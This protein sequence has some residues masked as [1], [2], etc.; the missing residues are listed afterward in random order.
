MADILK[1]IQKELP[2]VISSANFEGANIVLY[3]NDIE[4]FKDN[5]GKIKELVN[6]FKKRIE[7]RADEKLLKSEEDTEKII[8]E[9]VPKEAELTAILFDSQRSIVVIEAKRPGLVIGKSGLILKEIKDNS[10]WIP[11]IQRSPAIESKI[12][13]NI[14]DV[15]YQNNNT[16]KKFLNSVGKKIYKEWNPE[17]VEEWIR[18]TFLGGGRQVGRSCFLLSTPQT[19]ILL[20]CGINVAGK[21]K[22]KFPY[23]DVS[24]FK[25]NELDAI[26]LSHAHLDHSGLIP[27]LFKMGYRGP[28][29][30]TAPTRDVSALL[31]LDFIGV[32]YKQAAAP[33][34]SSTDI[35][36]MVKHTICLEYNEVTDIAPDMRITLYNSGH[37]LGSSIVH[38]NI[39]NGA[40][41]LIYT[42]D[43]KFLKSQLLE[44][45]V[46]NFPRLE[47]MII[48]STY[49]GK[50][51]VLPPRKEAEDQMINEIKETIGQGGKVLIP[52]LGLGRAQETMLILA[53]A[54]KNNSLPKVPIYIDGMIWD[55]NGIHT[56][57]PDFLNSLVRKEVFQNNNPFISEVFQ[58]VGSAAERKQVIEGGPCVVLAT[59]GMLVGGAS[60]EYFRHFSINK[61]NKICF[62]CYQGPGSLGRQVQDGVKEVRM[63][64][65]G[66]E[67]NIEVNMN[68]IT[69]DGLTSHAGR[70]ELLDFANKCQPHPNRII[71]VHGEQSRC[72]DLA[73][74]I[75]KLQHTE[76]NV[77]RN[78]ETI[79]LR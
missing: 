76:T 69:I 13:E 63:N 20:D 36:E 24:E 79:R 41:N 64:I 22:E 16:R 11:Q 52:E 5:E 12:T 17:K 43:F 40:H 15:L 37:A 57:Y 25:I 73:S 58:R 32:A 61:N 70:T 2:K 34:F 53:E 78:L 60:V 49:G 4:F 8:R 55:I 39:G 44:R 7:L 18:I 45:A 26:I 75:Y 1:D 51:N 65:E 66:K 23:L 29:Y 62:V 56:A 68:V 72:L 14:R 19:K 50:N 38:I 28:V 71:I 48:E 74:S 54:M 77:P 67:E 27:Y 3:T 42:G 46:S 35:K 9:T 33:L 10:L 6:K 21:G 31:A 59:S 30:M 47:T